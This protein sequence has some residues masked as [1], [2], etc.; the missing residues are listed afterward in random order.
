MFVRA[1]VCACVHA[2]MYVRITDDS[3]CLF[4]H[5]GNNKY[6]VHDIHQY[7]HVRNWGILKKL[8]ICIFL[9]ISCLKYGRYYRIVQ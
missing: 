9:R 4:F 7:Y 8:C 3:K 6:S 2:C 5:H 1:C